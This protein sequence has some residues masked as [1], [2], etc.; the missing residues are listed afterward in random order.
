MPI[1]HETPPS[2]PPS[3]Q[4]RTLRRSRQ[5][6]VL[7]G[8]AG[9]VSEYLG[10]DVVI[11]RIAFVVLASMAGSGVLAYIAAW[12]ILPKAAKNQ[13]VQSTNQTRLGNLDGHQL[14]AIAL[15][16]VGAIA[17]FDRLGI[18]FDGDML[19]PFVLIGIGVAVLMSSKGSTSRSSVHR[20]RGAQCHVP[21]PMHRVGR[22]T[23]RGPFPEP[24]SANPNGNVS[25][26]K[27][28][29]GS[30]TWPNPT[31]PNP[32]S[33]NPTSPSPA[34]DG[35]DHDNDEPATALDEFD[36]LRAPRAH[37]FEAGHLLA[38]PLP[39]APVGGTVPVNTAR[40]ATHR[41][42]SPFAR[43]SFG[44]LLVTVGVIFVAARTGLMTGGADGALA[45]ALF[46][47][48]GF[49][50]I[51]AWLGRPR[52]FVMIG[53]LLTISLA[54]L[55]LT[56]TDWR[57]G[58][59]ERNFAPASMSELQSEYHLMGGAMY[60]NLSK[61][62]LGETDKRITVDVSM[63]AVAIE[64]P[65][66]MNVKVNSSAGVGQIT[67]FGKTSDGAD[68]KS[69]GNFGSMETGSTLTIDA[70]VGLGALEVAEIGHLE[71]LTDLP[72]TGNSQ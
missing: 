69:Q 61:L 63:G 53:V 20:G 1:D 6:K 17:L 14:G 19:L 10:V 7:G 21:N 41:R 44:M 32:T 60:L 4:R 67:L 72:E 24:A 39:H 25:T 2:G 8:V 38:T 43:S 70:R 51:G 55:S 42:R 54:V 49:L 9:G 62:A 46:A 13:S 12:V 34:T 22:V 57:G 11:I 5:H 50:V 23:P 37:E 47:I 30:P 66:G 52:G 18:G 59:G 26:P 48:G 33:P 68:V 56:G 36:R 65:T 35:F 27:S 40:T 58:F 45:L 29:L 71:K 16:G 28:G 15:V 31:S 3:P 64:V